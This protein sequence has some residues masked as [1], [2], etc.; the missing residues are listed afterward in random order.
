MSAK[1][2]VFFMGG[3]V[4]ICAVLGLGYTCRHFGGRILGKVKHLFKSRTVV[5]AAPVPAGVLEFGGKKFADVLGYPP[6]Y[7]EVKP[8]HSVFFVTPLTAGGSNLFHVLNTNTG[9]DVQ[10]PTIADFGRDIG[11]SG[12][13]FRDYIVQA[14]P[15]MVV[16]A[17]ETSVG[18]MT[19]TVYY[20]NLQTATMQ[21]REIF[22]Y[23]RN[24]YM[25]NRARLPGF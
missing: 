23:D 8:L 4:I 22:R 3:I 17:S 10:I 6:Y 19:K 24:G 15:G 18:V 13:G 14:E 7:L 1:Q 5:Q 20:L 9:V 16:A 11:F 12:D 21:A 25:T 2:F